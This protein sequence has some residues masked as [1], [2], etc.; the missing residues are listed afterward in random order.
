M[1]KLV[2]TLFMR[3]PAL[4][5]LCF[6]LI[7]FLIPLLAQADK[8]D[9]ISVKVSKTAAEVYRFDVTVRHAD[10]GWGHYANKWDILAPDG[11]ILG[12]RVLFHPHVSEQPFTRSLANVKIRQGIDAITVRAHDSV[13]GY[14]GKE[15]SVKIP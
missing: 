14:G 10:D 5:M 7:V 8:A 2:Y 13:H 6:L 12:T 3:K 15:M 4:K 11:S 1:A 9:V